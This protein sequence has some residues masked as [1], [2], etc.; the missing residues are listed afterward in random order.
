MS[1]RRPAPLPVEDD[2]V[3]LLQTIALLLGERILRDAVAAGGDGVRASDGFVFQHL[4]PGPLTVRD[5][6][7]RLG[8]TQQGASKAVAD[9]EA[10]GF[11]ERLVD[12]DDAR[13]RP[14]ALAE[15][16][17]LVVTE[18]RRTRQRV[19]RQVRRSLGPDRYGELLR[20]LAEVSEEL[21]GFAALA[22][23]RLRTPT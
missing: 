5:L 12:T 3:L 21:G 16:G 23:R 9:L 2:P 8:M 14:V 1:A 15:R 10:R 6:A 22:G 7:A 4:V 18:A 19:A 20:S 13:R 11:V 17:W